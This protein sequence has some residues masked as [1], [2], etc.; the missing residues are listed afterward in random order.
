MPETP[1][2]FDSWG[3]VEILGHKQ[4]AG[5]IT[6]ETIA[7]AAFIRIDVPATTRDDLAIAAYTKFVGPSSVYAIS[8]ASEEI[9]RAAAQ[10]IGRWSS[11]LPV[12]IPRRLVAGARATVTPVETDLPAD[13]PGDVDADFEKQYSLGDDED[14]DLPFDGAG[15]AAVPEGETAAGDHLTTAPGSL[16]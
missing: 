5:R 3:I 4:L 8:P 7:G 1:T 15:A 13:I 10:E 9:A 16:L 12:E 6:E 14:D 2:T 11:P